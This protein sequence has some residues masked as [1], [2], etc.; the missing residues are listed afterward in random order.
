MA[1]ETIDAHSGIIV[2]RTTEVRRVG[3]RNSYCIGSVYRVAAQTLL[4]T[5]LLAAYTLERGFITLVFEEFHV[6]AP[7]EVD[8][9]DT[10]FALAHRDDG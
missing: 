9:F 2:T 1:L 7:H 5:V 8:V 6:I 3:N 4:E 10:G